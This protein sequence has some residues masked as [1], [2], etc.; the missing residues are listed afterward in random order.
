MNSQKDSDNL[1]KGIKKS[2]LKKETLDMITTKI[3]PKPRKFN[4]PSDNSLQYLETE[5]AS[6]K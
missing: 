4:L 5:F 3:G 6:N 1:F 2:L